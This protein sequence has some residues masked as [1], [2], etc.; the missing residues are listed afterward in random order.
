MSVYTL[1]CLGPNTGPI[2]YPS[3]LLVSGDAQV[4]GEQETIEQGGLVRRADL[5]LTL[6]EL[7]S[8]TGGRPAG[9]LLVGDEDGADRRRI[10]FG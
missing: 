5:D 7:G 4:G 10:E 2:T 1:Q 8:L 6:W 3:A 9:E